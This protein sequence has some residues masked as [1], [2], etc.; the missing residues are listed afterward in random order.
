MAAIVAMALAM[1]K[2]KLIGKNNSMPWHIPGEQASFKAITMGKPIIM[3]RKTYDSIGRPLPGRQNIVVTRNASW[4]AEG[5]DA[6]TSIDDGINLAR[7][8]GTD[9]VVII[10]GAALC[11]LAMPVTQRL[12]LTV[13]DAAYD[14]D[15]WLHSYVAEEWEESSREDVPAGD[16]VPAYSKLV[17]ERVST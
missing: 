4:S 2:N 16:E 3:G 13:V 9:E 11:E 1:D 7:Q 10:G 5:V 15:T 17:L 6:V 14:G 8:A 12:Y